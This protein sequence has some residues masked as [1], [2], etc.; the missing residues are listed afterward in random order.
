MKNNLSKFRF[1]KIAILLHIYHLV[2][3]DSILDKIINTNS[4]DKHLLI[5]IDNQNSNKN[6]FYQK[7]VNI[8]SNTTYI[9][10]PN[11]GKDIGAKLALIDYYLKTNQKSDYLLLLHDKKSPQVIFGDEWNKRLLRIIDKENINIILNIFE[12]NPEV[13]IICS[14]ECIS[15]EFDKEKDIFNTTNNLI[16][17]DYIKRFNFKLFDYSFVAGTMFWVRSSI[18]E[19][20]FSKYNP[21]EIRS[22]LEKGNVMDNDAGT[23]THSLERVFS[24]IATSQGYKIH[25][26]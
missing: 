6:S 2:E 14:S 20:F 17:K 7:Y 16:L 9:N 3:I 5:N 13:G 23:K 24:W 12:K 8:R 1:P 21:L 11:Q 25:G 15:N 4:N 22:E 26:I 19:E 10:T 18:F